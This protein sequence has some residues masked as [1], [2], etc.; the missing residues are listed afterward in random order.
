MD[1]SFWNGTVFYYLHFINILSTNFLA[2][3][4]ERILYFYGRHAILNLL[5]EILSMKTGNQKVQMATSD[6]LKGEI[7]QNYQF[8]INR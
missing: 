4:Q 8:I 1:C 5:M 2:Q 3:Y 6:H 7:P